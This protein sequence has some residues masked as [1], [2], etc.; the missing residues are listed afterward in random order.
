MEWTSGLFALFGVLI[1]LAFNE[2]RAARERK[3]RYRDLTFDKRLA[4]HQR[5]YYWC[6]KLGDTFIR[7]T[8]QE[9]HDLAQAA[10]E[11][12]YANCLYLEE[13]AKHDMFELVIFARFYEVELET[14][15]QNWQ[16][17]PNALKSIVKGIGREYLPED[18]PEPE[19]LKRTM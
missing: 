15:Y 11:W 12:W 8:P 5:A 9:L 17:I 10:W 18:S 16:S 6:R 3:E 2:L 13:N 1:A 14:K 7:G 4:A 19:E